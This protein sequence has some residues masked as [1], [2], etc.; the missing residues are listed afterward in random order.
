MFA[1]FHE[2]MKSL[3]PKKIA[4]FYFTFKHKKIDCQTYGD[5]TM[6]T[7]LIWR[8]AGGEL[9]TRASILCYA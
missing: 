9:L 8:G 7:D 2:V 3:E 6:N 5:C 1:D 4:A